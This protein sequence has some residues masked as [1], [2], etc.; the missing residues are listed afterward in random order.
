M[1]RWRLISL[2][3][4]DA[5]MNMAIDEAIIEAV[6][7]SKS[8]N[9]L[10]FY[11]WRPSAVSIGRFQKINEAVNLEACRKRG[12]D[13]VRR[14]TGGGAVY[15]DYLGEITYSLITRIPDPIIPSDT[16]EAYRKICGGIVRALRIL[17]LKAEFRGGKRHTCPDVIVHRKKVSGNAQIRKGNVILQHGTILLNLDAETMADILKIPGAK[18]L[19]SAEAKIKEGVTSISDAG[20]KAVSFKKVYSSLLRGFQESL[21]VT[22]IKEDLR[23]YE[24][25][26]AEKIEAKYSNPNWN[27]HP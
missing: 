27:L 2:E 7:Q 23:S 10:R 11:R 19:R 15:H 4:H 12:I 25:K 1:K 21:G 26:R 14:I 16:A 6:T 13:V 9:T 22:L 8:F 18:S 3:I 17:E 20:G 24:L 5:C